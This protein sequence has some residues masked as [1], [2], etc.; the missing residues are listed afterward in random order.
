MDRTSA[1]FRTEPRGVRPL[2]FTALLLLALAVT[3][4]ATLLLL[5]T[6]PLLHTAVNQLAGWFP[7]PAAP[8]LA[9]WLTVAFIVLV[10]TALLLAMW[11]FRLRSWWW[12]GGGW[13]VVTPVLV[14]LATDE[15]TLR[16]SI[17][18]AEISPLVP[19]AEKSFAVIMR[20][21]KSQPATLSFGTPKTYPGGFPDP[22]DKP[23]E[24]RA[25]ILANRASLEAE[26]AAFAPQRAWWAE[27]NAFETI[28]DLTP[29]GADSEV[30]SFP[31]FR[32]LSQ[33]AWAIA[34]LQA[35]DGHGDAAIDTLL[36]IL[37]V[38][39]KMQPAARTLVRQ[40]IGVVVERV[41][42]RT[43]RWVLDNSAVSP[44]ARV[45]LAAALSG[46]GGA[47]GAR[48]LVMIDYL[49]S[50]VT[51]TD[52]PL[53]DFVNL[54]NRHPS[55]RFALNLVSPF[56]YNRRTCA[57]LYGDYIL[58]LQDLAARREFK[59][60]DRRQAEFFN[61]AA[62]PGFKNFISSFVINQT[63]PAYN[64]VLETYWKTEDDRLALLAR[65]STN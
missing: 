16:H 25:F 9:G 11:R 50:I 10:P 39:R 45:R 31:V 14:Y 6:F 43:V 59:Q 20:Y 44:A 28:G 26:W 3:L 46:G 35:L 41:S 52:H 53:G 23:A 5:S 2:R 40:M 62:R 54:T 65:L 47:L 42:I 63:V 17:S 48:R 19:D 27:L 24:W 64:K 61:Q 22:V 49:G 33:R 4:L 37:Q 60:F 57:N 56:V 30:I 15:S 38:G 7:D 13:L 18:F 32:A 58:E 8:N 51:I 55:I 1:P 21:G 34:S 29:P 12:V 36:P